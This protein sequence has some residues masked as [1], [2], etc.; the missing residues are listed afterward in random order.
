MCNQ[1]ISQLTLWV[2]IPLR[3]GVLDTTLWDK[4]CQRLV[5]VR[6]FSPLQASALILIYYGKCH[7]FYT[8]RTTGNSYCVRIMMFNATFNNIS[9]ISW[10]SF[11]WWR[12]AEKITELPQV[13]D[14]LYPIMLYR[15]HLV[16][17]G[18]ELTTLVVK[19]TGWTCSCKSNYHTIT[20]T[21]VPFS[22][23]GIKHHNPNTVTVS[24][25]PICIESVTLS[26][27]DQD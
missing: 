3:R 16:W 25:C 11:Y 6:W 8:Y 18:F 9:A 24:C 22:K 12:K 14:K 20:T 26:I 5:E 1:C 13:F 27:I 23:S 4:V 17:A 15:V 19:C 21:T 2:R 10:W 7:A